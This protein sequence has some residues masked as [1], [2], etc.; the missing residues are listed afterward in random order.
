MAI[1]LKR[2]KEGALPPDVEQEVENLKRQLED[3]LNDSK[4]AT[5]KEF[6][7]SATSGGSPTQKNTVKYNQ[8]GKILSWDIS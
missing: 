7:A 6:Y 5:T 2:I 4:V 3:I 1:I 8:Y